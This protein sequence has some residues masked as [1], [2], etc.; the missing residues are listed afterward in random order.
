VRGAHGCDTPLDKM[1]KPSA[2]ENAEVQVTRINQDGVLFSK[3][4]PSASHQTGLIKIKLN[5]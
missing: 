1:V 3:W 5:E 2:A 4:L